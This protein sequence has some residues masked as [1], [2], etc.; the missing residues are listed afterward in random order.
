MNGNKGY[1]FC[2]QNLSPGVIREK[3]DEDQAEIP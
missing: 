2:R 1:L 3:K